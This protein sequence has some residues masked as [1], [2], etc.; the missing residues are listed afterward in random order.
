MAITA[1]Q[2]AA[3]V[4][5]ANR[6]EALMPKRTSL[7]SML[8]PDCRALVAWSA[9]SAAST[10]LPWCSKVVAAT[11]KATNSTVIAASTAQPCRRSP[12]MRPNTKHSAAGIRKMASI[13]TK[14]VTAVGFSKGCAELA[15]KKPPPLVPTILMASCEATG[16]M[17]RVC[18][19]APSAAT[20]SVCTGV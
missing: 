13:C 1:P 9:P 6:L 8:P 3:V 18:V 5:T 15:L 16:P 4:I 14:F 11:T 7:P 10:G 12:T 2:L 19:A 17:A 20:S